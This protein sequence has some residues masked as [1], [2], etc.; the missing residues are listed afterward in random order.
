MKQPYS[1]PKGKRVTLGDIATLLGVSRAT[2][3]LALNDKGTLPLRRREEIKRVAADLN[4][5]P[6]PLAQA[7]RGARTRSIGVVTNYFSNIYF[8]DFY[9]GLEEVA[10]AKGFS[11]MVSQSYED[12]EKERRQVT[13]FAE[14]GV[15]GMIVLPC[16]QEKEHLAAASRLGIPVVLISNTLGADFAAV[17]A[18]NVQGTRVAVN[19]LLQIA[20]AAA[21]PVFHIAGPQN[22][23]SQRQRKETFVSVL[24]EASPGVSGERAVYRAG[25]LR[26]QAGYASLEA[27]LRE[28]SPPFSL[29]V[30]N[31][32]TATGVIR[33]AAEHGLRM[34]E[35]IAVACFSG[36]VS[37]IDMGLPVSVVAV[38]AK[39]M[40]ETTARLILDMMERPEERQAP[41]VVTLPVALHDNMGGYRQ[42]P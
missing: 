38:Q 10:D 35:D 1:L 28:H 14:Y 42:A 32:E 30:C 7:L 40:G 17:V 29:F 26:S 20:P 23:S 39:R 34:P 25:S 9:T 8:R 19:R 24:E 31:D 36:D 33:Y 37:L 18:D 6:N 3:S 15:D 12:L 2:V 22:Q 11:F 5:V 21:R 13:R 4:Y 41:P 16:S 27:I